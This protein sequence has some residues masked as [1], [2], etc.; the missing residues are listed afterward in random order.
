MNDD[1]E[2]DQYQQDERRYSAP[3]SEYATNLPY[4][5]RMPVSTG[6]YSSYV[7]PTQTSSQAAYAP[8]YAYGH[9]QY[10]TPYSQP[11]ST[12]DTRPSLTHRPQYSATEYSH[13]YS[14][15]HSVTPAIT[16]TTVPVVTISADYWNTPHHGH[17]RNVNSNSVSPAGL[18]NASDLT[19]TSSQ[20]SDGNRS[21]NSNDG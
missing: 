18:A 3:G 11:Y 14:P 8:N 20:R 21:Q 12:S 6:S 15:N 5:S 19:R 17:E 2:D 4:D 1:D 7:Y 9:Q 10:S 13:V 16:Y